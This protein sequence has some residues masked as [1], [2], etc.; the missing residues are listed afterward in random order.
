VGI[1]NAL[2]NA[3][4]LETIGTGVALAKTP[5]GNG[6]VPQAEINT[7][8]NILA[9]CVNSNGT[10]LACSTLFANAESGGTTG[11]VAGDT[12]TAA[13][14]IA[15]NPGAGIAGLYGLATGTPAFGGGLTGQPNDWT[16]AIFFTEP[17]VSATT[18]IAIDGTGNAWF[19]DGPSNSIVE[20]SNSGI[21]LSGTS[22]Y[23]AGGMHFPEMIAI[24]QSGNAWVTGF[25]MPKVVEIS[26]N[27]SVLSGANGFL[28]YNVFDENS[29][30]T[31]SGIA[32]DGAGNVWVPNEAGNAGVSEFANSGTF[33]GWIEGM[34]FSLDVPTGAAVDA[35]NV[36]W[37]ANFADNTI[38]IFSGPATT[39]GAIGGFAT[40]G[41]LNEPDSV[42]I[43][44]SGNVWVANEGNNSVT[45][46]SH[47]GTFFS[48]AGGF[49][50]SG[51]VYPECLVVDGAGNVW[52]GGFT[53]KNI[54][55]FSNSGAVLS[56]PVGYRS[57]DRS[58]VEGIAV[59]G[60]GNVWAT[61]DSSSVSEIVGAAVPVVTPIA[62]GVTTNMLGTRP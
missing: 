23:T 19:G 20:L 37:T 53:S 55:E 60:S 54:V 27:G 24:D 45:K 5:A 51:L 49:I 29:L 6:T 16:L 26:P 40:G 33:I 21:L 52:V 4:N 32:V 2:A 58:A 31:P 11:T 12:A 34:N 46:M 13:I 1:A 48:G 47:S 22:G 18:A 3:A 59:D 7:L 41:G 10:G 38:G 61:S 56:G 39:Y 28:G 8:A 9:A 42:A 50:G 15:H 57:G 14:N 25:G 43:D 17:G 35:S 44:G 36:V 30:E 62:V